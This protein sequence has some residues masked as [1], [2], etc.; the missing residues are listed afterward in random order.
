MWDN[1]LKRDF[2]LI[3]QQKN[4]QAR[5]RMLE[6]LVQ[7]LFE[8]ERFQV[9]Y[10]ARA[11]RPR[12]TDLVARRGPD[13]FV[14]EVKWQTR[15]LGV[16]E[17]DSLKVRLQRIA[18]PVIGVFVSMADFN[19]ELV[20]ELEKHRERVIVVVGEQEIRGLV[21]GRLRLETI[22]QRKKQHFIEHGR[23]LL[24][25]GSPLW[26]SLNVPDRA[27]WPPSDV[28]MWHPQDG[29][30]P[31]IGTDGTFG[32][33]IFAQEL[34]DID[35]TMPSGAGVQLDLPISIATRQNIAHLLDLLRRCIGVTSSG[36]YAI[37]QQTYVWQGAG[38]SG[39]LD[40]LDDRAARYSKVRNHLHHSEEVSYFDICDGGFYTLTMQVRADTQGVVHLAYFSAQLVGVPLDLAPW[41][42]LVRALD[43]DHRAYFRPRESASLRRHW[44]RSRSSVTVRPLAYLR[45]R[46]EDW[47][48][49]IVVQNPFY[50]TSSA[51]TLPRDEDAGRFDLA[52]ALQEIAVL[53]CDLGSYHQVSNL[54]R[55]Y[56]LRYIEVV[57]TNE[58][59]VVHPVA[60]WD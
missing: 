49:G 26:A 6:R 46:D 36:R 51:L 17:L 31:W 10:N 30:V 35:Q 53:I 56:E 52:R 42:E 25:S 27:S 14:V 5:G 18:D 8:H 38:A 34:P 37:Q 13:V 57:E 23:V 12:Q 32:P 16:P 19:T 15:P 40:A 9:T 58:V 50:G 28:Q 41:H 39:L 22:L 33:L 3:E 43:L 29:T 54:P 44:L 24:E 45:L 2:A 59:I 48:R 47:I 21:D 1:S 55:R 20:E 60:R 7:R 11:A 4:Q